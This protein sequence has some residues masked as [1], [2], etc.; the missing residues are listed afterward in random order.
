MTEEFLPETVRVE[1]F[2]GTISYELLSVYPDAAKQELQYRTKVRYDYDLKKIEEYVLS[3]LKPL[4]WNDIP[5]GW[6]E[7]LGVFGSRVNSNEPL[8]LFGE[9]LYIIGGDMKNWEYKKQYEMR[10]KY[11]KN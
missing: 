2:W 9:R 11:E 5:D 1:E 4:T 3:G 8:T 7:M 10:E 6:K